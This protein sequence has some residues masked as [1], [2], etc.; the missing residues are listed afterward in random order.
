MMT[1]TPFCQDRE[2]LDYLK[3]SVWVSIHFRFVNNQKA[4]FAAVS[5]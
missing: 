4:I 3:L 5:R 2:Q 1:L